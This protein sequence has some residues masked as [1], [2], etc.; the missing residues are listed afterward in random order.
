MCHGV[1]KATKATIF[2]IKMPLK[3]KAIFIFQNKKRTTK[4][5]EPNPFSGIPSSLYDICKAY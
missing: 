3:P 1:T 5:T 4:Q 2:S